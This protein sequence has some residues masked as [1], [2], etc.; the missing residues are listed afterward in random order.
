MTWEE[1]VER[2]RFAAAILNVDPCFIAAIRKQ[3]NGGEGREFGV[4]SVL[5][6][7]Y[8][9]QLAITCNTVRNRIVLYPSNP[10]VLRVMAGSEKMRR[11][12]YSDEFI[13]YFAGIW[14]P[15]GAR[16]DPRGLNAAWP[17]GVRWFYA[18]FVKEGLLAA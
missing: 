11:V 7:G 16:N 8:Q 13:G 4:L 15:V 1:E 12:C 18:K 6:K 2:I 5:T 10:L 9:D 3:E 14:A 17:K